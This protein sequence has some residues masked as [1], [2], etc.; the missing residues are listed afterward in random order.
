MNSLIVSYVLPILGIGILLFCFGSFLFSYGERFK[1]KIQK[2]KA[3]GFDLEVSVITFFVIVGLILSLT[4]A[5][6]QIKNYEGQLIQVQKDR[7]M[8][9]EALALAKKMEMRAVITLEGISHSNMP[10]LEDVQCKFLLY[11]DE[12]PTNVDVVK[13]YRS[14]Q[15]KIILRYISPKAHIAQ[16]V[17][18]DLSSG[19]KWVKENFMPLEPIYV[20]KEG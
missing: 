15:F 6:F 5:Y 4:G 19:K 1:G 9:K 12:E 3:F 18:E 8:A 17:L 11:G 14:D 16:L 2:V 20:L 10:K 7:D 13:G